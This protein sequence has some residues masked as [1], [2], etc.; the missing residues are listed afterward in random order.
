MSKDTK[1]NK[2][3]I[4]AQ[5]RPCELC[6]EPIP[7]RKD[8]RAKY[9]SDYCMRRA[10]YLRNRAPIVV[11]CGPLGPNFINRPPKFIPPKPTLAPIDPITSKCSLTTCP[12]GNYSL[13]AKRNSRC[14]SCK[15]DVYTIRKMSS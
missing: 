5:I 9:C 1:R 3:L 4:E 10:R 8:I 6:H 14:F 11:D 7:T 13:Q 12:H 2:A 15:V